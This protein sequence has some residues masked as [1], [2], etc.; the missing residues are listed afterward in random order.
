[1]KRNCDASRLSR[2]IGHRAARLRVRDFLT[3]GVRVCSVMARWVVYRSFIADVLV[4]SSMG[5]EIARQVAVDGLAAVIK[6]A[7]WATS[8]GSANAHAP[9]QNDGIDGGHRRRDCR[10]GGADAAVSGARGPRDA[11]RRAAGPAVVLRRPR[12]PRTAGA[13]GG[14]DREEP[15]AGGAGYRDPGLARPGVRLVRPGQH[16]RAR[17]GSSSCRGKSWR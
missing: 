14:Q 11:P 9:G 17:R 4:G 3:R 7:L 8:P 6:L 1:M 16:E 5:G 10:A 13:V 2:S 15:L 12:P